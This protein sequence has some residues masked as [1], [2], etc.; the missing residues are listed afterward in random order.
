[1]LPTTGRSKPKPSSVQ[2]HIDKKV[3]E[4]ASVLAR[5]PDSNRS[6]LYS[7]MH[8][9]QTQLEQADELGGRGNRS[10]NANADAD[11]FDI[12][13]YAMRFVELWGL[14]PRFEASRNTKPIDEDLLPKVDTSWLTLGPE[15]ERGAA[16]SHD[17]RAV[18]V[19]VH[20]FFENAWVTCKADMHP[21]D[22]AGT[23][24][25]RTSSKRK[26]GTERKLEKER[27]WKAVLAAEHLNA[28]NTLWNNLRQNADDIK[29]KKED[30]TKLAAILDKLRCTI[31]EYEV[32]LNEVVSKDDFKSYSLWRKEYEQMRQQAWS[33]GLPAPAP[34]SE[35][36]EAE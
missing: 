21:G 7:A 1:M 15:G 27:L 25:R 30:N 22:E 4:E 2:T 29:Q 31:A 23:S 34:F 33:G 19:R 20:G 32:L 28:S 8:F 9:W 12:A 18:L 16:S 13:I 24:H 11:L 10:D 35:E 17:A 14:K 6:V 36:G 3:E 26:S 5:S